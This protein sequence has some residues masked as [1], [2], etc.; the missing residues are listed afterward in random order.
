MSKFTYKE[1]TARQGDTIQSISNRVYGNTNSWIE[2]TELN[3]L[4][5]PY[6]V[7][8]VEEKMENPEGLRTIGDILLIR[9]RNVNQLN[10]EDEIGKLKVE[11]K[12]DIYGQI[13]GRGISIL[14][15][16][17]YEKGVTYGE[18]MFMLTPSYRGGLKMESGLEN[19]KQA[20]VIRLMTQQ[21]T[22][23]N[24][25]TFGSR[26]QELLGQ[27]VSP[28]LHAQVLNEIERTLKTDGR[29]SEVSINDSSIHQ[30]VLTMDVVI[31]PKDIEEA[32]RLLIET[33]IEG[34]LR[35]IIT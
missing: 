9:I 33:Q 27:R 7:P 16:D 14:P 5:H 26:L 4:D 11:E 6:L 32:Y 10:I 22:Y 8:T 20:L 31:V 24:H 15:D 28:L 19:L 18:E 2:I 21:G 30:G 17:T 12:E 23:L 13:L 25:P 34:E 29:V 1:E 3:G 35:V